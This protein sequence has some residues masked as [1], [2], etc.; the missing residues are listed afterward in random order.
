VH[1]A[2][3]AP[4]HVATEAP[5]K[6]PVHAATESPTKAPLHVPTDAPLPTEEPTLSPPTPVPTLLPWYDDIFLA[7]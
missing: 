2:T 3:Q 1:V 7:K 4:V 6:A 5:T